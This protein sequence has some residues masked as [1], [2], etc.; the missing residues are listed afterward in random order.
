MIGGALAIVP[1][2]RADH[3]VL[4]GVSTVMD[5]AFDPVFGEA[6]T[7]GQL[8]GSLDLPGSI[9]LAARGE[10]GTI[11]F[12]LVRSIAGEAELLLIAVH[13]QHRRKGIGQAL[14]DASMQSARQSGAQC[15]FLEVRDGNSAMAFYLANGFTAYHRRHQYYLGRDGQRRDA[16]SLRRNLDI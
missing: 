16:I 10:G 1:V 13:P 14:L 11:G 15:F 6:W 2:Q 3:E 4:Y 7:A 12:A 8:C 5:A 9:L